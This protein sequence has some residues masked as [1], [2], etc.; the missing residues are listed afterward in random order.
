VRETPA[1]LKLNKIIVNAGDSHPQTVAVTV[2]AGRDLRIGHAF[3]KDGSA[4]LIANLSNRS[5]TRHHTV[6]LEITDD[7]SLRLRE[8]NAD[9]AL[10]EWVPGGADL[11]VDNFND[12]GRIDGEPEGLLKRIVLKNQDRWLEN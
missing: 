8:P 12:T 3:R 1:G 10:S 7:F 9:V 6:D 2:E 5:Q 11:I 4:E